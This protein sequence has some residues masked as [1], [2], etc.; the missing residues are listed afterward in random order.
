MVRERR[1]AMAEGSAYWLI[2]WWVGCLVNSLGDWLI[3]WS[4]H[5]LV[6]WITVINSRVEEWGS[7]D[8]FTTTVI[9]AVWRGILSC[10]RCTV[11]AYTWFVFYRKKLAEGKCS[12]LFYPSKK[13]KVREIV[14]ETFFR[15]FWGGGGSL[16]H[17][18]C[19]SP[20]CSNVGFAIGCGLLLLL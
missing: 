18:F 5:R 13:Q 9:V 16:D 10:C 3:S 17:Q 11:I 4:I 15:F 2:A 8:H 7:A 12:L 1:Q 19:L 6:G 14:M 20:I